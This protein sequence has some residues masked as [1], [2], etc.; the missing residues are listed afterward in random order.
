M[1]VDSWK[2]TSKT[3]TGQWKL[4][5]VRNLNGEQN[6]AFEEKARLKD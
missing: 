1:A 3:G 6:V 5:F 2:S 4:N